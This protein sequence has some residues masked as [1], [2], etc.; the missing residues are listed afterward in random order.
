MGS[1]LFHIPNSNISALLY[2]II[3][4]VVIMVLVLNKPARLYHCLFLIVQDQKKFLFIHEWE[5]WV[6]RPRQSYCLT[7]LYKV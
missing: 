3:V 5:E 7:H 1:D 6:N 2:S 4:N